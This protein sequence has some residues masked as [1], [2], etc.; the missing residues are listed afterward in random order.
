MNSLFSLSF[1]SDIYRVRR[2]YILTLAS[3][4]KV[5]VSMSVGIVCEPV[6]SSDIEST[7]KGFHTRIG[8]V[9]KGVSVGSV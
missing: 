5:C 4:R 8:S 7:T 9:L 1:S 3:L 2:A 6:F